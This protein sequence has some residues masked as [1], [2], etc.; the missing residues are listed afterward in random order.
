[1]T[2][3]PGQPSPPLPRVPRPIVIIGAGGIVRD[4]HLPAYRLAGFPVHGVYDQDRG[5]AAA[6]AAAAGIPRVFDSLADAVAAAPAN[7]VFDL[8][9]PAAA[10][11]EVLP[12]L[13]DGAAVLLQK[14][15]GQDLAE[16][17]L[18]LESCR[19]KKLRAAVN[20]QLRFAPYILVARQLIEA[21]AIGDVHDIDVRVTVYMPWQLWTFLEG[22]PR[23]EILYHSIH[24]ID[25]IRSFLGEPTGVLARTTRHPRAPQLASARSV[26]ALDYGESVRATITTNH[27]HD[28]GPRHQESYVK[29]EGT[30]GAI[31]ARLGLLLDYPRGAP[32]GL[33]IC[34][35]D[36]QGRAGDWRDVPF[37][38]SWYPH[39]FIGTMASVMRFADGES[40]ALPTGADD[41]HRTMAVVEAAYLA[42]TR[43]PEPIPS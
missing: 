26:I 23:V 43:S 27:G 14:P 28:F 37:S 32:D 34:T 36:E 31:K 17:K 40:D 30:R 29:W 13:P 11:R 8:A 21:G 5:K 18:L 33:E 38:G 4:A 12:A 9:V 41:A 25:L 7:A 3:T 20:F 22:L 42:N 15:F 24:Y 16:A 1:M 35:I 39:A 2:A 10:L 6:L 19:R